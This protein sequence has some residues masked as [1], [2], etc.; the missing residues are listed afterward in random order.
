[1]A[2]KKMVYIVIAVF[3][4]GLACVGWK[5]TS[6]S[7]YES[8]AYSV[9][10]SDGKI[11]LREYPDLMMATT[12]MQSRQG[13]D[14]SFGRLFRYIS[15]GNEDK[16]KV[17]MTTPVFMEISSEKTSGTMGFVIPKKV[18]AENIPKPASEHVQIAQRPGGLFAV[19]RFTGRDGQEL[20]EEQRSILEEWIQRHGYKID[21]E[22]E[23]AGYDPPWTPG[24]LRRN[25]ILIRIRQD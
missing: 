8:A 14:G 3:I 12:N 10:K 7:A 19:I 15:G 21:G 20:F 4:I 2:G 18:V 11:E 17:A 1:M 22:P 25:E 13:N 16:Q 23:V 9:L 6:R 5:V 24:P